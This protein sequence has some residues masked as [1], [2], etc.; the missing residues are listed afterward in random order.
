MTFTL[1]IHEPPRVVFL[2]K[3]GKSA[4][5]VKG[6]A[7]ATAKPSMPTVGASWLPPE[8][9]TSTNRKPIM[10]PV[11]EKLT[12]ARVKAMRKMLN[13][14]VVFEALASIALPHEVGS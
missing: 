12:S 3:A 14:P 2:S 6:S 5:R 7:N 9:E 8:V 10:G 1:F 4:K 13:K 11:H